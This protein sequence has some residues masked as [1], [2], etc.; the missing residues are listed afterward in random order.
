MISIVA[1]DRN[2]GIGKNNRMPW[3]IPGEQL[4]FREK[5]WG[6]IVVMGRKTLES[7]PGGRPLKGRRNIVMTR[8]P[9]FKKNGV[10]IAESPEALLS[11]VHNEDPGKVFLIGGSQI[12]R[13]LTPYCQEAYITKV[14]GEYDVDTYHPDLDCD[15]G[16][17]ITEVSEEIISSNGIS[18]IRYVYENKFL[19]R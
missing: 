1:V 6:G 14:I 12:Y 15:S 11:L 18:Y 3:K 7:L 9:D 4:F 8:N 17:H 13:L 10:E 5:T 16:W 2:W 19:N